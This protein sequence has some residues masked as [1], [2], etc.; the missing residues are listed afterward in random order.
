[1]KKLGLVVLTFISLLFIGMHLAPKTL[2]TGFQ[3]QY[4]FNVTAVFG[5]GQNDF[6]K[7]TLGIF[8]HGQRLSIGIDGLNGQATVGNKDFAFYVVDGNIVISDDYEF[9]VTSNTKITA[10]FTDGTELAAVFVDTNGE[11]LSIDYVDHLTAPVAPNVTELSKP[12]FTP[13]V[14]GQLDPI[15]EHT[16]YV[17]DYELTN[18]DAVVT[19]NGVEYPYNS[20][21]TLIADGPFT[22]WVEDGVIVSYSSTYKFSALSDRTITQ[23]TGGTAQTMVTLSDDLGLRTA[24]GKSS[25][26]GQ[27]EIAD[28]EI[29]I[30]A[31]IIASEV[32]VNDLTLDTPD[33]QIIVSNAIQPTTNEFLRTVDTD[34]FAV[35]RGYV[36]TSL[37]VTYSE[38]QPVLDNTGLKI[39][40][41]YGAGGNSGAT[42]DRDFL[43][44]KNTSTR[45]INLSDYYVTYFS[46]TG[47]GEANTVLNDYDLLPGEYYVITFASGS[48]GSTL[49]I[50]VNQVYTA[51]NAGASNFVFVLSYKSNTTV[52]FGYNQLYKVVDMVGAG[53]AIFSEGNAASA[54]STTTSIKRSSN[55]DTNNNSVDF[56][57]GTMNF[58]Y[59]PQPDEFTVTFV[60]NGGTEI[61]PYENIIQGSQISSPTA[62]TKSGYIFDKWY[63]D[64][65]LTVPYNFSAPVNDDLS[66]YANWL[67]E[68]TV[69]F[70]DGDETL[71]TSKV[72]DN[73]KV[74]QP[75]NPS[76]T[77][78]SFSGWYQDELLNSLYDF[79]T[80]ITSDKTVYAKFDEDSSPVIETIVTA[81]RATD[82]GY[83][84]SYG[85]TTWTV[86]SVTFTG[87]QLTRSGNGTSN[88]YTIQGNSSRS[89]ASNITSNQL[90]GNLQFVRITLPTS[91]SNVTSSAAKI[92]VEVSQ[93]SN[94][95][96][97][98]K[99]GLGS[100]YASN[101]NIS[102]TGHDNGVSVATALSTADPTPLTPSIVIDVSSHNATYVRIV[103]ESGAS[104]YFIIEFEYNSQ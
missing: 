69:I 79:D 11:F 33:V 75:S 102:L 21:I 45:T 91:F 1:M 43:V 92:F 65:D 44:I 37:G 50:V 9:T 7:P 59:L 103:W 56:T 99:Y 28:G 72:A 80:L 47:T 51:I 63:A 62:P 15:S 93:N 2:A 71:F 68:R 32:Y 20:V 23:A 10:V 54:P 90:P 77:G 94:F 16:V 78:F 100:G 58:S 41:V 30:E 60:T 13:V 18:P 89:P 46:A 42:Y 5:E 40:E 17:V 31:G 3:A 25:Y 86:G 76:K 24:E 27:F 6:Y 82:T 97:S 85:N 35:V 26:L 52:T 38:K 101:P 88:P 67:I 14:F 61:S 34:E 73:T 104:Y 36:K 84:T 39:W 19:I 95:L 64:I 48:N 87:T 12:G 8:N 57:A 66:L 83:P 70:V 81:L 74:L 98:T 96:S 4:N 53:T 55:I 22:H 49:P 29:F